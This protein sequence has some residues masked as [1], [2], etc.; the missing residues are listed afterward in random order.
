MSDSADHL[1]RRFTIVSGSL[2]EAG[3]Q[4]GTL[5]GNGGGDNS[6]GDM[7]ARIAKLE[8]QYELVSKSLDRIE[9]AVGDLRT[10][11]ATLLERSSH[12]ATKEHVEAKVGSMAVRVGATVIAVLT[13]VTLLVNLIRPA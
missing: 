6:G 8:A 1:R 11:Q 2:G 13:V 12:A 4:A 3:T 7:E 9:S 10:G 5:K